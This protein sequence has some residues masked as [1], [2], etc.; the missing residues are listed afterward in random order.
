[1][2]H[3][4]SPRNGKKRQKQNKTKQKKTQKTKKTKRFAEKEVKI[5][6]EIRVIEPEAKEHHECWQTPEARRG[7]E[8]ILLHGLCRE[9]GITDT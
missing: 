3:G 2:C 4:N 6:A 1:M 7:K 8:L 9:C 5:K